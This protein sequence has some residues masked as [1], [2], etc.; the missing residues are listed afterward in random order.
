MNYAND[1][2]A[3]DYLKDLDED[4]DDTGVQYLALIQLGDPKYLNLQLD[5]E[6]TTLKPDTEM[7]AVRVTK[8]ADNRDVTKPAI[9][10]AAGVHPQEW[11]AQETALGLVDWLVR[12]AH[13]VA[14]YNDPDEVARVQSLLE[15][16]E[17]WFVVIANPVGR[18]VEA[19]H[20][21][22]GTPVY[23]EVRK[24]RQWEP[25]FVCSESWIQPTGGGRC[26]PEG[27]DHTTGYP[28]TDEGADPQHWFDP[29][30]NVGANFSHGWSRQ[31]SVLFHRRLIFDDAQASGAHDFAPEQY[32]CVADDPDEADQN[33]V[34][35]FG[36]DHGHCVEYWMGAEDGSGNKEY[37]YG[38]FVDTPRT[39]LAGANGCE[40][41]VDWGVPDA[42]GI[43]HEHCLEIETSVGNMWVPWECGDST[44]LV[45]GD[46]PGLNDVSIDCGVGAP[47]SQCPDAL[48]SQMLDH[49][50]NGTLRTCDTDDDCHYV[51]GGRLPGNFHTTSMDDGSTQAPH[52]MDVTGMDANLYCHE[53][54][55]CAVDDRRT[56]CHNQYGGQRPFE[57]IEA[58]LLRELVNNVPF[59]AVVDMHSS[60]NSLKFRCPNSGGGCGGNNDFFENGQALEARMVLVY[61]AA[62]E[63]HWDANAW[64][65]L[66]AFQEFLEL[67][68]DN[69]TTRSQGFGYL[70][71][72]TSG[73][74]EPGA[75]L[76]E[77]H[78]FD[79]DTL[80]ALP[81]FTW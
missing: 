68:V 14:P 52:W 71:G 54:G 12:A 65:E 77:L 50:R 36:A 57:S 45:Y 29:G 58:R 61:N 34:D 9:L 43:L 2:E 25:E 80:K 31:E 7:W 19:E 66:G 35:E 17:I 76:G 39:S 18:E 28:K 13:G 72:W 40:S 73:K 10:L 26:W 32:D 21:N 56:C 23:S 24:N 81:L 53:D 67:A 46:P 62:A 51:S 8:D 16:R 1:K 38:C 3:H 55:Y 64:E 30:I 44:A 78:N 74:P 63:D 60:A 5:E 11:I 49:C 79:N 27:S 6:A 69:E 20:G 42:R 59:R 70:A 75:W 47:P 15:E 37:E 33:C 4:V 41:H 48:P 22:W